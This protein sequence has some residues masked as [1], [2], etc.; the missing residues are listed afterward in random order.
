MRALRRNAGQT[1]AEYL[2]VLLLVSVLIAGVATSDVGRGIRH[3]MSRLVC[4]IA[5]GTSCDAE[6]TR[7]NS[8]QDRA[9]R[10][11]EEDLHGDRRVYDA[12]NGDDLPGKVVRVNGDGPTGDKETDAVHDNFGAIYDY[13]MNNFGRDSYDANGAPLIATINYRQDPDEP[14]RNAYWDP[15]R[16]QMVFGEGF[17]QPLDVT[18]H[19][20]THAITERSAHL[21][22]EGESGA[23]N[24]SISD[25]FGSNLD[26][27]DWLMGEDLPD[28]AIRD[29]AHPERYGQ[30]GNVSGYVKTG[31]D[32]GGVHTNSGIPN[33]AYVNMVGAIGRDASQQIVYA[34]V[35]EHLDSDSGFED[36]RAG[37]LDAAAEKYGKNSVQYRGV[38]QAF[39]AVGLDGKWKAP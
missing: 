33:K 14:F 7:L 39:R 1:A 18:A 29:M 4:V 17:A 12:A 19:E 24:E 10:K 22:Y 25:I 37:C 23:L 38:D 3:Q 15:Q 16:K 30:P 20:V 21:K 2:G 27:G 35:T 31:D 6:A 26:P 28:G 5:G 32:N 34:A 11:A 9:E 36:F 8:A 13:F